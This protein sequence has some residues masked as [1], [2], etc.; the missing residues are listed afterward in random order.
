M[1]VLPKHQK[2]KNMYGQKELFWGL[3]IEA[4]TYLQFKKP[5]FVATPLIRHNHAEERYSVNYYSSFLPSYRKYFE[6]QFPDASGCIPLPYFVN[7]H[8]LSK[9]DTNGF[10]KTTYAKIPKPNPKFSGRTFF[11]ELQ[12]F[13]PEIFLKEYET[14]FTF[15]G[16]SIEFMTLAF[17]KT[18]ARATIKELVN[19]KARFL[20]K[21]NE[22]LVKKRRYRDKGLLEYPQRNPGWA[23]FYTN[24]MNVAMFNSGTYHINIT[25][26]SLLGAKVED[27]PPP[28]LYPKIF[29]QQH[30]QAILVYQWLEPLLIA[31]YGTPD[32]FSFSN[33][34]F[35]K[36]SQRCAMSRYIGVGTY[37]TSE[38]KEGKIL[39][40]ETA[41]LKVASYPFWWYTRYHEKSAYRKLDKI[42]LDINY[43]KHFNHG[44]EL[45]FFDWFPED[46]LYQLL[47]F[48]FCL[49]DCSLQRTEA[50]DPSISETWNDLVLGIMQDGSSFSLSSEMVGSLEKVLGIFITGSSASD[51]FE[52]IR[53][54]IIKK[55]R[56]ICC[57]AML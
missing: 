31:I 2:Y 7:S 27:E 8:A 29:E 20:Q 46:R 6:I 56:G 5:I 11:E 22:F 52:N 41:S 43:K 21:I 42:G 55:Y 40:V 24:P 44:I 35:C 50:D 49:A 51:I 54:Q 23:V 36:A 17:Y 39:T 3:G 38:M 14:N 12:E 26:P 45:R 1:H 28:L 18:N 33:P 34:E 15:D 16:D 9:C 48:I 19:Y 47:E 53:L 25:I 32:P 30:K 13:F 4:E 37:D 57:K 10:H